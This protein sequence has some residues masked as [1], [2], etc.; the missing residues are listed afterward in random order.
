MSSNVNTGKSLTPE[1]LEME[2]QLSCPSG[3]KGIEMGKVMNDTNVGMITSSI[4]AL[5]IEAGHKV[6]ELGH[7]NGGHIRQL[8]NQADDVHYTG[9]EI[10]DTMHREAARMIKSSNYASQVDLILYDGSR[11]PFP[12]NTFDKFFTVNTIYFWPDPVAMLLEI[13]RV[14]KPSASP[15]H[16]N[17]L[18]RSTGN[19]SIVTPP[20][21][22]AN[23][24]TGSIRNTNVVTGSIGNTNVVTHSISSA[25]SAT[26]VVTYAQKAF[27]KE[28]PF[29][30]SKFTLYDDAD[31]KA[32]AKSA[33]LTL[34]AI[35]NLSEKVRSKAG[36]LVER[37]YSVALMHRAPALPS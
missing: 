24:V 37:P 9:I 33:G 6:L 18:T 16:T 5:G 13:A 3:D 11:L 4:K 17:I 31:M 1:F 8:L 14:L 19:T 21:G 2:Q 28:L 30:G 34:T 7:G 35:Q 26:A 12:D 32:L 10:S 23:G 27:M 36:D 20:I 25:E 29:V 15:E 22:N